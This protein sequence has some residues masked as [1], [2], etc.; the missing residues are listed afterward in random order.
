MASDH[1]VPKFAND[2]GV[3]EIRIGARE[4]E[5]M[6]ASA[7]FDHPHVYLDMGSDDHIVC[8]YCSTLYRFDASLKQDEQQN[9]A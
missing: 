8:P 2:E 9:A 6:G 3:A 4:F 7:P 5:C 1:S